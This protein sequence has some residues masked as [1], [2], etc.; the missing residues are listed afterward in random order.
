MIDSDE[1][2]TITTA[3]AMVKVPTWDLSDSM[4][5]HDMIPCS[6]YPY[7]FPKLDT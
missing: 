3:V 7:I 1:E 5:D 4:I 6:I 2:I